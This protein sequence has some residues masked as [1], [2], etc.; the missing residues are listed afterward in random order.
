VS[1][2]VIGEPALLDFRGYGASERWD[3]ALHCYVRNAGL[4]QEGETLRADAAVWVGTSDLADD[5]EV[6]ELHVAKGTSGYW[7]VSASGCSCWEGDYQLSGPY[8]TVEELLRN[9]PEA[10]SD[11]RNHR[12]AIAKQVAP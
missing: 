9:I 3:E 11:S 7:I 8:D 10:W 4:G 2:M 5:Y 6:D 12:A 1:T